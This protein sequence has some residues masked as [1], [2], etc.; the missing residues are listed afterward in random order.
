M[1]SPPLNLQK[2]GKRKERGRGQGKKRVQERVMVA[3][4]VEEEMARMIFF[5]AGRSGKSQQQW[6]G[7]N[8]WGI[9]YSVFLISSDTKDPIQ[10]T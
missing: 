5:A 8:P 10:C 3:M 9:R 7:L 1:H 4:M 6:A 2:P